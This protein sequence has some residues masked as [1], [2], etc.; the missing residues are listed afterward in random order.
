[1]HFFHLLCSSIFIFFVLYAPQPL[2]PLF[3]HTFNVS[4]A[5]AG[6]LMT[7]TM[8]PLAIAPLFYGFLFQKLN[9]LKILKFTMI[10]LAI[11][12]IIFPFIKTF[13]LLLLCRVLQ[14]MLLPA[15][16]TAMTSH[17]GQTYKNDQ[18]QKNMTIYIGSTI[19]GGFFGRL[20]AASFTE[21]FNWQSFY[22]LIAI[23]LLS[24]AIF[25]KTHIKANI[26]TKNT[27][28]NKT[29][30]SIISGIKD[31]KQSGLLKIYSAVFCMFFCFTAILNYLPFILKN[32]FNMQSTTN[33]GLVYI[34]YLLGAIASLLTPFLV[35]RFLMPFK[36]LSFIFL[37]YCSAIILMLSNQ[38]QLF[39]IAFS[40][41]CGAMFIIHSIAAPLVNKISQ[42]PAS[43]TNG[44]YVSFYYSGGALGS[45]L[46]GL[47]YQ[48][49]GKTAFLVII[50]LICLFGLG[51]VYSGYINSMKRLRNH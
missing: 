14:G 19:L 42:A 18:L 4:P 12:C 39:F 48:S 6:S 32:D 47:V 28:K 23:G 36:L 34:G 13:E 1:M 29:S 17:I 10:L 16:L 22:Y 21:F 26:T 35:K 25:I 41:F 7:A 43:V 38:F 11:T 45:F 31:L 5:V 3:S 15:A 27:T 24:F 8:I 37:I 9:A 44:V 49:H 20:L 46:P 30:P 40:L 33:I 2:L 51:L 50:L